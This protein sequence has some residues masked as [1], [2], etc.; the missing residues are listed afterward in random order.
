MCPLQSHIGNRGTLTWTIHYQITYLMEYVTNI[1]P[2]SR[3]CWL[4]LTRICS[5]LILFMP[6]IFCDF[7]QYFSLIK[8]CKS[9]IPQINLFRSKKSLWRP[10]C[11][12]HF[13][14]YWCFIYSIYILHSI[15]IPLYTY[16]TKGQMKSAWACTQMSPHWSSSFFF[17]QFQ[18]IFW[19]FNSKNNKI[20][21]P[22]AIWKYIFRFCWLCL[23]F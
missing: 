13:I 2:V 6:F 23:C 19:E 12:K 22:Y 8:I 3:K 11:T 10:H 5:F 17:M 1:V 7:C 20:L 14:Y 15:W 9:Q 18:I 4:S 21:I 16:F